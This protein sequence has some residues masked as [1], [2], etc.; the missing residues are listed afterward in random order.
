MSQQWQYSTAQ[1]PCVQSV[2]TAPERPP[3]F[4]HSSRLDTRGMSFSLSRVFELHVQLSN[5]TLSRTPIDQTCTLAYIVT[6]D[7]TMLHS[8]AVL[9]TVLWV[10]RQHAF[11]RQLFGP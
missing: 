6:D 7:M 2:L 9:H 8:S 5:Q 1:Q 11:A 4:A 3:S 10:M